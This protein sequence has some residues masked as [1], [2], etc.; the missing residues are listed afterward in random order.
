MNSLHKDANRK[1]HIR[2]LTIYLIRLEHKKE[3]NEC[4]SYIVILPTC[5]NNF[6]RRAIKQISSSQRIFQPLKP[7]ITILN[8]LFNTDFC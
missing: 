8:D 2:K 7:L 5:A 1:E 6:V 3:V 4:S